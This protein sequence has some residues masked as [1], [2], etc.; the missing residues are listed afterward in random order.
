MKKFALNSQ[1]QPYQILTNDVQML[2]L[3]LSYFITTAPEYIDLKKIQML[4]LLGCFSFSSGKM[5]LLITV[6]L[7]LVLINIYI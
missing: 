7:D 1:L 6:F 5:T 3:C 2:I 4:E